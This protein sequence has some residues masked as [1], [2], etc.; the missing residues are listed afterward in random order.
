MQSRHTLS[1]TQKRLIKFSG[2]TTIRKTRQTFMK[3]LLSDVKSVYWFLGM[4][5][6]LSQE[7]VNILL[8]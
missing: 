5:V 8:I 1:V 3:M 7:P 4:T 2:L 6:C